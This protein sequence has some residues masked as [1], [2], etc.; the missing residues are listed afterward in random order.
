MR[1]KS[2]VVAVCGAALAATALMPSLAQAA[3]PSITS[4]APNDVG[5]AGNFKVIIHGTEFV[6]VTEVAYG[7]VLATKIITTGTPTKGQCKVKSSTELECFTPYH[8]HGKV[9]ILVVTSGGGASSETPAD[10]I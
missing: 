3:S 10:E 1:I 8:E 2:G 9:H 4:V 5:S 6:S 7:A